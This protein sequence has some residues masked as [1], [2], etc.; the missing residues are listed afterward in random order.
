ML[1]LCAWR[2]QQ[3]MLGRTLQQRRPLMEKNETNVHSLPKRWSLRRE[4][5]LVLRRKMLLTFAARFSTHWMCVCVCVCEWDARGK[6]GGRRSARGKGF[7]MM[8]RMLW[9][10]WFCWCPQWV[11]RDEHG[12]WDVLTNYRCIRMKA[13]R[14]RLCHRN[15]LY[16]HFICLFC[17]VYRMW[18]F[19]Y[20]NN[21][22]TRTPPELMRPSAWNTS[23][24][25]R[26][27]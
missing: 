11:E 8:G 24:T 26:K 25:E 20:K 9:A 1:S 12:K 14:N 5:R 10:P 6:V 19:Q 17:I 16:S 15:R 13:N 27:G 2:Q 4:V 18:I 7:R 22:S 21:T 23:S 3:I